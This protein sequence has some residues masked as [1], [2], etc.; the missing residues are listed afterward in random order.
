MKVV[1]IMMSRSVYFSLLLML[2]FPNASLGF[3]VSSS[4]NRRSFI[5]R[6]S[7]ATTSTAVSCICVH[8]KFVTSC[9]AYH[10][11][12]T[13]H[14]QPHMTKDP[15]F[16]PREG[17][18]TIQVHIRSIRTD[19][20]RQ[21]EIDRMWKEHAAETVRAEEQAQAKKA[22]SKTNTGD[23]E[24]DDASDEPVLVGETTYDFSPVT[25]YEYDVVEC[26]DFIQD[27]GCWVRNMPEEIRRANPNFV[28]S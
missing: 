22:T 10:F 15:T 27:K 6:T 18:P 11:V 26:E 13:K 16:T 21:A 23:E 5:S 19:E 14:E 25:T 24:D 4:S 1:K 9:A 28:P 8:C 7:S 3:M 12:E 20:D 17:S 2:L